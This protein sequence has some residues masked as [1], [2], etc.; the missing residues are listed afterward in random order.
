[1][2]LLTSTWIYNCN[3]IAIRE[4]EFANGVSLWPSGAIWRHWSESTL[5]QVMVCYLMA[6]S[7]YRININSSSMGYCGINLRAQQISKPLFC[8]TNF[9]IV[10]ISPRGQ[11]WMAR[12]LSRPRCVKYNTLRAQTFHPI[13]DQLQWACYTTIEHLIWKDTLFPWYMF[14]EIWV[15]IDGCISLNDLYTLIH[16]YKI[17]TH[18]LWGTC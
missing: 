12:I 13:M 4:T 18:L 1:M 11:G 17:T 8:I 15:H 10:V 9:K 2:I 6:P 7:H 16:C 3:T 5:A 14:L